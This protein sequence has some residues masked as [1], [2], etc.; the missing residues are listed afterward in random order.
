MLQLNDVPS[1]DVSMLTG[2]SERDQREH[3][4]LLRVLLPLSSFDAS[5][6]PSISRTGKAARTSKH[7]TV[8]LISDFHQLSAPVQPQS[9][10]GSRYL[11]RLCEA[12]QQSSAQRA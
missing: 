7:G 11:Q 6:M 5:G 9:R 8:H 3:D 1:S 12:M 2:C 10:Y 4:L